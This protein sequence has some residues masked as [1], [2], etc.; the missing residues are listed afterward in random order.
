MGYRYDSDQVLL[1]LWHRPV[2]AA[3]IWPL[4]WELSYPAG[5]GLKK[6]KY[7]FN[8]EASDVPDWYVTLPSLHLVT[9]HS[10]LVIGHGGRT[11]IRVTVK[12]HKSGLPFLVQKAMVKHLPVC[13][14]VLNMGWV[15][16]EGHD[17]KKNQSSAIHTCYMQ[18]KYMEQYF[19]QVNILS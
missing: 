12:G 1:W 17:W 7:V 2:A 6:K 11:Y 10:Y 4:A 18:R 8:P 19:L 14:W 13:H 9:L 5:A 15:C 16:S 3:L